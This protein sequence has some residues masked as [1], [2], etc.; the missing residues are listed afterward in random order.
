M[1]TFLLALPEQ[2]IK[3]EERKSGSSSKPKREKKRNK[4]RRAKTGKEGVSPTTFSDSV[5]RSDTPQRSRH[6]LRGTGVT[7]AE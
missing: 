3:G 4:S 2:K 7:M 5:Q 6:D 1:R